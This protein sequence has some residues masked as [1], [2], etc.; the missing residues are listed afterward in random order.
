M[1]KLH[2]LLKVIN[3]PTAPILHN[4]L[5]SFIIAGIQSQ[6]KNKTKKQKNKHIYYIAMLYPTKLYELNYIEKKMTIYVSI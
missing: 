5:N 2:L 1:I 3:D 4:T 6:K